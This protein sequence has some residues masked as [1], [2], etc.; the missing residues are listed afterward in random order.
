[1]NADTRSR[2][3]T[4]GEKERQKNKLPGP[5]LSVREVASF[6]GVHSSTVRRWQN[7]GILKGHFIGLRSNLRFK[8]EDILDL[9][10]KG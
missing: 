1:M 10:N 3:Q 2:E 4:L 5:L 6:F 9:L 7:R 8:Q